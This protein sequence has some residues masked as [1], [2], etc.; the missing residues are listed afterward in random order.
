MTSDLQPMYA[1][2]FGSVLVLLYHIASWSVYTGLYYYYLSSSVDRL[3]IIIY[4]GHIADCSKPYRHR[5]VSASAGITPSACQPIG[6]LI[7][8]LHI[9]SCQLQDQTDWHACMSPT[10]GPA[11]EL[12]RSPRPVCVFRVNTCLCSDIL[13]INVS[14]NFFE[15]FLW[16]FSWHAL[17]EWT[18][19]WVIRIHLAHAHASH[20]ISSGQ[21]W[22]FMG[23]TFFL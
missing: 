8:C 3:Y 12:S 6:Y 14:C 18:S 1:L 7:Y 13:Y 22:A 16:S 11:L 10:F 9:I 20:L 15:I 17:N 23:L 19:T 4:I 2:T 21:G 5:L